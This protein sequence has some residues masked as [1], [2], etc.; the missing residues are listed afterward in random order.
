MNLHGARYVTE[1]SS[2]QHPKV[3]QNDRSACTERDNRQGQLT[4]G[5]R[6]CTVTVEAFRRCEP[7][8]ISMGGES[9]HHQHSQEHVWALQQDHWEE[10]W[11][12]HC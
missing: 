5:R 8:D 1:C 9:Q 6:T 4:I 2:E 7:I 10:L 12:E 11:I 3:N